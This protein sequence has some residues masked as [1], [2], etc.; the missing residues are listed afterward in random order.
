M[1]LLTYNRL[2]ITNV[3]LDIALFKTYKEEIEIR[4][5]D[6]FKKCCYPILAGLIVDYKEQVFITSIK[7]NMECFICHILSK[8]SECVIKL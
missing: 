3:V 5:T 8:K 1:P 2:I 6:D 4:Y 7:A